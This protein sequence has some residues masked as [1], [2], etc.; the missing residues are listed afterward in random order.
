MLVAVLLVTLIVSAASA[1]ILP[2]RMPRAEFAGIGAS[3]TIITLP[4]FTVTS[5]D[6]A[7][8]LAKLQPSNTEVVDAGNSIDCCL[9]C[10]YRSRCIVF[11]YICH[12]IILMRLIVQ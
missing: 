8:V 10:T 11:K 5:T 1:I 6:E 3:L 2:S 7:V 9:C 12:C 4:S